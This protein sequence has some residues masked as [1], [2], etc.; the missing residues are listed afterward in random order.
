MRG[1]HISEPREPS[2]R[3]RPWSLRAA[4]KTQPEK[5]TLRGRSLTFHRSKETAMA[6]GDVTAD[7]HAR[8]L[9][10]GNRIPM[11]GLGVWQV[12]NG[13]ECI[14]AVRWALE[15]GYRHIDMA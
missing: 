14:D 5:V 4:A 10:D 2:Y 6:T 15:L 8:V 1:D 7:G 12:P 3:L 13:P 9:A 11:L